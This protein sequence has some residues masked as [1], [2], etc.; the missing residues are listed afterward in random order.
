M[1]NIFTVL[2]VLMA[3]LAQAN[4]AIRLKHHYGQT[5]VVFPRGTDTTDSFRI[6]RSAGTIDAGNY[7]AATLLASLP[8]AC[9][10]NLC[11]VKQYVA[12][13]I[14]NY[15]IDSMGVPLAADTGLF[16]NTSKDIGTFYYGVVRV[17]TG[18]D[19]FLGSAS[20]AE[21]KNAIT[22]P[23][24]VDLKLS[25]GK[26]V[27]AYL[28]QYVDFSIWNPRW[29]SY[30]Y[31][32]SLVIPSD[33][34]D[35]SGNPDATKKW[36]F[37]M[38]MHGLS[39]G[40]AY[41]QLTGPG[42]AGYLEL[43][44]VDDASDGRS[45][46]HYGFSNKNSATGGA[47][48]APGDTVYNYTQYRYLKMLEY[49]RSGI[50]WLV[51]DSNNIYVFGGSMGGTGCIEMMFQY[52]DIFA[53]GY[54]SIGITNWRSV[55]DSGGANYRDLAGRRLWGEF[56]SN[57]ICWV[58]MYRR[59]KGDTA[60]P[61][62]WHGSNIWKRLS[63]N[64][65]W[66]DSVYRPNLVEK[67]QTLYYRAKHNSNDMNVGWPENGYPFNLENS[68]LWEGLLHHAEFNEFGGHNSADGWRVVTDGDIY[69]KNKAIF[70]MHNCT[71]D[72]IQ[73]SR[74]YRFPK[75]GMNYR[76]KWDANTIAD[77]AESLHVQIRY[78]PVMYPFE[79]Y[80]LPDAQNNTTNQCPYQGFPGVFAVDITPRRVQ[81]FS[82]TPGNQ[83]HWY[84]N[85]VEMGTVTAKAVWPGSPDGI[86]T[87]PNYD[88]H[89]GSASCTNTATLT[90]LT[91][92]AG[93]GSIPE[94]IVAPG[95]VTGLELVSNEP[96]TEFYGLGRYWADNNFIS[97]VKRDF[98]NIT[99]RFVAPG[100]DGSTG[101]CTRYILRI[102]GNEGDVATSPVI[103]RTLPA[104]AAADQSVEFTFGTYFLASGT[105][106][107]AVEAYDENN[108]SSG[109]S[110]V[111]STSVTFS[112]NGGSFN[113][114]KDSIDSLFATL[115]VSGRMVNFEE[116][117]PLLGVRPNPF[118]PDLTINFSVPSAVAARD[119]SLSI[120]NSLGKRVRTY[121]GLA[122]GQRG[123]IVWNGIDASG[124]KV[125][126]GAYVVRLKAGTYVLERTVT[127][128]K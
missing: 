14:T 5:F 46:W 117:S 4:G 10:F 76:V 96:T 93:A 101:T 2:V 32:Y 81:N 111:I 115:G 62:Y 100:D 43:R 24:F 120:F 19:S 49:I 95:P 86:V 53:A 28:L 56:A 70:A 29:Q 109:I 67:T 59:E 75:G 39:A 108:N 63:M 119:I 87:I 40:T 16:V 89:Q 22:V 33:Y 121:N 71:V 42:N 105:Y 66:I 31:P 79:F 94:D 65:Y 61:A 64:D 74:D 20:I 34:Y 38:S 52:P 118:N 113:V 78:V 48:I 17:S 57:Q 26:V 58:D 73:A 77:A 122:A 116:L 50:H 102:A 8:Y 88:F 54:N 1:L 68:P 125:A 84:R 72:E 106:Y 7:A 44:C 27:G 123:H 23:I 37:S 11:M 90:T 25:S 69:A 13:P 99:L 97:V 126:S 124:H 9:Y 12:K 6:Y 18:A 82:V 47:S 80:C 36:R 83:Y 92:K 15:V 114:H 112:N 55:G 103:V 51:P 30:A 107:M 35:V 60:I 128:M 3:L 110:N 85:G 104:P 41:N 45:T 98:N 127:L 91:I 21:Q